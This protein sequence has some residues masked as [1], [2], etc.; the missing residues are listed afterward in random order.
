VG[1]VIGKGGRNIEAIRSLV[2]ASA[3]K[4]HHRVNVEVIADDDDSDRLVSGDAAEGVTAGIPVNDT[5]T[6]AQASPEAFEG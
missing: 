4:E 3:I 2:K 5:P 1:R 6:D